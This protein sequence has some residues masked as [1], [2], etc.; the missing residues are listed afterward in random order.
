M[1]DAAVVDA[2]VAAKW[3]LEEAGSESARRLF[4][5]RLQAPEL[6]LVECASILWKKVRLG[7]LT[8]EGAAA[9]LEAL[10]Q[11]PVLLVSG[12]ELIKPALRLA[13]DLSHPVYG[14]L[15]L[16]LAVERGLPLVTADR[17]FVEA[18]R[19]RKHLASHVQRLEDLPG[20]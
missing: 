13:V 5:A 14:C 1:I 17:R 9:R 12:R 15:Y 6:L 4:R 8:E 7:N 2:S 16:A 19:K 11:G 20:A 18:A 3:V 10:S